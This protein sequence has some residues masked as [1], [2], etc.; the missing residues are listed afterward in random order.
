MARKAFEVLKSDN[1]LFLVKSDNGC[2]YYN[3]NMENHFYEVYDNATSF[4]NGY[5]SIS[6]D[7]FWTTINTYGEEL[8][9]PSFGSIVPVASNFFY[10]R[11]K[12]HYGLYDGKGNQLLPCE[13]DH[14][15]RVS[16]SILRVVK[17][18][19]IGYLRVDGRW[20]LRVED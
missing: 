7:G 13:Y 18:G 8:F 6:R 16:G 10:A 15:D 12:L 11:A 17:N 1:G 4:K 2:V 20:I 3:E 9:E 14:I 5:A 19:N